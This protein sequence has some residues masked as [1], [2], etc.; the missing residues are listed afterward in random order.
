MTTKAAQAA[1]EFD[2]ET[3]PYVV[4]TKQIVDTNAMA[5]F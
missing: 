1:F 5:K 2:S 4:P 3:H